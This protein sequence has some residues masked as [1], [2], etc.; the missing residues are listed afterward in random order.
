MENSEILLGYALQAL[1]ETN[2]TPSDWA[3]GGGTVL[4][5][6]FNHRESKDIDIFINDMQLLSELS[7]RFNNTTENALDYNE[8]ANYISLTYPE[9]KVDFI[10]S[11]QITSYSPI[12]R[13]FYGYNIMVEDPVEIVCKK[14]FYR[15]SEALPRDIFDLAIV[16]ESDRKN[17]L[18]KSVNKIKTQ[19]N[20][21]V[22]KFNK[23]DTS[24]LYSTIY[25]DML[26][27]NGLKIKGKEF[28]ICKKFI[29]KAN[30]IEHDR[31]R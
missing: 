3:V 25:Q 7:P 29:R 14:I 4:K 15:G 11:G 8:M 26:L 30:E 20:K 22:C 9:G 5:T 27:E 16:Y 13:N 18:L 10:V 23:L 6:I 21:F 24:R 19:F 12:E 1:R 17:D 31:C 2:V 28:Y